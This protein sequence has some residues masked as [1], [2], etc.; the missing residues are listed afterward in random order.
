MR[1]LGGWGG[2]LKQSRGGVGGFNTNAVVVSGVGGVFLH[3]T[4][5]W[6][7]SVP[8]QS[9]LEVQQ[10]EPLDPFHHLGVLDMFFSTC[11][12]AAVLLASSAEGEGRSP[13]P[14]C[15][16]LCLLARQSSCGGDSG[17]YLGSRCRA[18]K[19]LPLLV[20]WLHT[21][22]NQEVYV[23]L[24]LPRILCGTS[25][26]LPV[27]CVSCSPSSFLAVHVPTTRSAR[28]AERTIPRTTPRACVL[29]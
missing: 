29:V 10:R 13:N 6:R 1:L 27:G 18:G 9:A 28:R 17:S 24:L 26:H 11:F 15:A 23:C 4:S 25:S 21:H 5:G 22:D 7:K 20:R 2:G 8:K 12:A 19:T 3:R 14:R 16:N